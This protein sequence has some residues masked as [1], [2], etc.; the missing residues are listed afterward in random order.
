MITLVSEVATTYFQL[1]QLDQEME[2]Q[3]AATN[4]YAGSYRIF[5]DRL[6]NGVASKLETDRAAAALAN[7]AALIPQ[8]EIQIATTEDQLNVLLGRNPGPIVRNSL[9]NQPQLDAGDSRRSAQR[10][11]APPARRACNPNSR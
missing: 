10:T 1:L 8:I 6:F 3:R 2:I 11:V 7:A 9:T 4:A 5:N